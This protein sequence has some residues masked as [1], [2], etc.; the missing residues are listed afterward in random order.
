[1]T[2]KPNFQTVFECLGKIGLS[3]IESTVYGLI[4]TWKKWYAGYDEDFHLYTVYNGQKQNERRRK[5]LGMAQV[6]CRDWANLLLNEK[7]AVSAETE[8]QNKLLRD[9]FEKN[10]F[11][12]YANRLVEAA[13]ALGTG[14]FTEYLDRG[15][16]T[17]DYINADSIFPL[18]ARGGIITSCAFSSS[19]VR[20]GKRLIYIQAHLENSAR[21]GSY[22]VKNIFYDPEN[23][24]TVPPPKGIVI[25]PEVFSAVRTF[26]I[27][28]PNIVN[29]NEIG[30][31]LGRSVF[32]SALDILR[33]CDLV[34]DSFCNDFQLGLKR[35]LIPLSMARMQM[36]SEGI[37]KPVFDP[38][39][40]AFYAV[41]EDN[42]LTEIDMNIR[43]K[44]HIDALREQIDLLSEHCGLG[45]H[46]FCVDANSGVK[47]AT[48]VIS[49]NSAL[50]QNLEKH[51][52]PLRHALISLARAI[53]YL[54]GHA[55]AEN[56][57][58]SVDFDDSIIEDRA[59]AKADDR[60]D[61]SIGAM[62]LAE[63]RMKW[64]GETEE[65]AQASLA[66]AQTDKELD[67]EE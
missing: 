38:N 19:V 30:S 15:R 66:A 58:I 35:I 37:V 56:T 28:S 59:S 13:F 36:G 39:D 55:D 25:A 33:G 16:V 54:S 65:Q 31:P 6:V 11:E 43:S 48:E 44:E 52:K 22:T 7:T 24:K 42:K 23:E 46:R 1:M 14:A 10:G 2:F 50:Y 34:Y 49:E 62:S 20:N 26:Q 41:P 45:T 21:D 47:T 40:V 17:I 3:P 32:A 5:T 53:L 8:S 12:I 4:P 27:I 64:Y 57:H 63:Y 67:F 60:L 29:T 18:E 51:R 61:V 9:A